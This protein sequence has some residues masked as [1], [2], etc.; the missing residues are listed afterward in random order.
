MH[1]I[2]RVALNCEYSNKINGRR[3]SGD[4]CTATVYNVFARVMQVWPA[5]HWQPWTPTLHRRPSCRAA[6]ALAIYGGSECCTC[7]SRFGPWFLDFKMFR[8][9][10]VRA[11]SNAN[12][13]VW[14]RRR[15]WACIS[16]HVLIPSVRHHANII[17][18]YQI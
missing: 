5:D 18:K 13:L 9:F 11:E 15:C 1:V 17:I 12:I 16:L 7:T 4:T 10:R 6:Y 3:A 8:Q 14:A 2:P